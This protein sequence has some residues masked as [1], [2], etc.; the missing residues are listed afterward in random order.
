MVALRKLFDRS[1]VL[2]KERQREVAGVVDGG[3]R[4][5]DLFA[6]FRL[7]TIHLKF[8]ETRRGD[9]DS[10]DEKC[11]FVSVDEVDANLGLTQNLLVVRR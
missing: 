6:R 10:I 9:F 4:N 1:T 5:V 2:W 8:V 7:T 11:T 3:R